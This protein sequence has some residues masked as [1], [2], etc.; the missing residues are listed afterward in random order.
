MTAVVRYERKAE[1]TIEE[2][3]RTKPNVS[4]TPSAPRRSPAEE[5]GWPETAAEEYADG[6]GDL[7]GLDDYICPPEDE[8]TGYAG[9]ENGPTRRELQQRGGAAH[10][11]PRSGGTRA[12]SGRAA[13]QSGRGQS[14]RPAPSGKPGRGAR[15]GR[16]APQKPARTPG[17]KKDVSRGGLAAVIVV[18]VLLLLLLGSVGAA[19]VCVGRIETV[20]PGVS[21][22]GTDLSG[23]TEQQ[24]LDVLSSKE[25]SAYDGYSVT[26][27]LPMDNSLTVTAEDAGVQL[28]STAAARAAWEYGRSGNKLA[29][30]VSYVRC[31]YLDE[32][33]PLSAEASRTLDTAALRARVSEVAARVNE[34]L[35]S[36]EMKLG[37]YSINIVK[38]AQAFYIDEDA[39]ME[40]LED[41]ILKADPTPIVYEAE[42]KTDEE[43]DLDAL[44]EELHC[45]A[46]SSHYD[47]ETKSATPS[48]VGVTFDLS[49]AKKTWAAAEYGETVAIRLKRTEPE[50][51]EE[52]LNSMLYRD[53]LG[54]KTTSLVGSTTNRISNVAKACELLSAVIMEPGDEF[55]YNT[56]LGQRTEENGWLPA[57]AYADGEVRDEYGGGICQVSSTL[58]VSCLLADLEIVDR[59]CHYFPVGYLTAGMDA[60]VS[61]GGPEY[62]FKNNRDLPIRLKA[63]VSEDQRTVTVQI[64]GTNVDGTHV[65]IN[66]SGAMEDFDDPSLCNAAGEPVATGYTATIWC[67]VLSA[68]GTILK[69][70]G[71][72]YHWFIS[73]Y[74]Y[75]TEDIQAKV[76]A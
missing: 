71:N 34:E 72:D 42:M 55:D 45:E 59:S 14:R 68:D 39:I 73:K 19:M 76:G 43:M 47:P 11:V 66:Y 56:T 44:Y 17:P 70:E 67:H 16:P 8:Y 10:A 51:S 63:F 60:T 29:D 36:S 62:K 12:P 4:R 40:V 27:A 20:Y 26:V 2:K 6:Y 53:L 75:H 54:E 22:N 13:A 61:W 74:H 9:E 21:V 64:W 57:P 33:V 48:Q 5:S 1:S 49:E 65:K 30:L 3:R 18:T 38:G 28:D 46:L 15:D 37:Q 23:M 69:G 32:K 50:V 35:L 52:Q 25:K 31:A 58:F 41:A 7:Y 24:A